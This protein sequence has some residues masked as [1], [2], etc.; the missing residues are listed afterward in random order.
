MQTLKLPDCIPHAR[1]VR[2]IAPRG[3]QHDKAVQQELNDC[4]SNAP[5]NLDKAPYHSRKHPSYIYIYICTCM[6][7]LIIHQALPARGH[8]AV[9]C[10]FQSLLD[11]VVSLFSLLIGLGE[12]AG[13][14]GSQVRVLASFPPKK[15]EQMPRGNEKET[16]SRPNE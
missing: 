5:S 13:V 3:S 2:E 4:K 10:S 15:N 8:Q 11:I 1:D 14:R 12:P 6:H 7:Q 16:Q 9:R